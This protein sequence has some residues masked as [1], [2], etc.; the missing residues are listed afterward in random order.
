MEP[1]GGN[2]LSENVIKN[3]KNYHGLKC[4]QHVPEYKISYMNNKEAKDNH[5][6]SILD[7][8]FIM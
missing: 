1:I 6:R 4:E 3:H 5:N 7:V 2:D 8:E